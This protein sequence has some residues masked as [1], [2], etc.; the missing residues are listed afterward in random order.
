MMAPGTQR[1]PMTTMTVP[2]NTIRKKEQKK[3]EHRRRRKMKGGLKVREVDMFRL[4]EDWVS[5]FEHFLMRYLTFG[6]RSATKYSDSN[7]L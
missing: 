3:Q 5:Y 4:T 2:E 7:F 1:T 6:L